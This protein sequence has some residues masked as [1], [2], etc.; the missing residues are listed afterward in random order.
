MRLALEPCGKHPSNA[1]T[2]AA[3]ARQKGVSAESLRRGAIQVETDTGDH[4]GETGDEHAEILRALRAEGVKIAA[5][6][7]RA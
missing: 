6:I 2:I 4:D 5:R 3:A 1:K 7:H